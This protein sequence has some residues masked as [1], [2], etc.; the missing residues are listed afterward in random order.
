M[1][2]RGLVKNTRAL[3]N[4]SVHFQRWEK[5]K[6]GKSIDEIAKEESVTPETVRRSLES[7]QLYRQRNTHENLNISLIEVLREVKHDIL[8]AIQ[9]GLNANVVFEENGKKRTEP[10]HNIQLKAVAEVRQL[11]T[12][13]QPK[14][15]G[16]QVTV[17]VAVSG[18]PTRVASTG[19][20]GMEDRLREIRQLRDRNTQQDGRTIT[21]ASLEAPAPDFEE[22]GEAED[23]D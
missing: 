23:E 20:I 6:G 8:G 2:S 14:G 21:V 17:G 11:A 12:V 22:D 13:V 1:A 7:V 5:N 3:A 16:P 15:G 10:D 4:H 19:Y 9:R 18:Q